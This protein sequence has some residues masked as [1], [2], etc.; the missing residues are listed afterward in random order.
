MKLY[1]R[2]IEDYDDADVSLL[3]EA[4]RTRL[5]RLRNPKVRAE[6]IAAGM[7][8]REA[9]ADY[10]YLVGEEPLQLAYDE[11]GKPGLCDGTGNCNDGGE[12]LKPYFSLSHSGG[13]VI[14]AVDD[15]PIGADIQVVKKLPERLP[16][17]VL[18]ESELAGYRQVAEEKTEVEAQRYFTVRWTEKE[19]IAKLIGKGIGMDFRTI[20]AGEYR[21]HT[22]LREFDG[23][24]YVITTAQYR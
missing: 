12:I 18:T 13:V 7:L 9:L 15:E 17:R 8:L 10:G 11:N 1:I 20:E 4:R 2:T 5:A 23:T 3:E 16:K 21:L 14:C 6:C 19:S 24:E 22:I